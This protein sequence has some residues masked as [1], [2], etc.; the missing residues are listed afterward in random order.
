MSQ[1]KQRPD[2]EHGLASLAPAIP[3]L[4]TGRYLVRD[5]DTLAVSIMYITL[6]STAVEFEGTVMERGGFSF[7]YT[8]I[9]L[10][11][12]TTQSTPDAGNTPAGEAL[13]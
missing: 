11:N 1:A 3:I 10:I 9:E 8:P 6:H 4:E 2:G 13:E 12:G 5:N 7:K